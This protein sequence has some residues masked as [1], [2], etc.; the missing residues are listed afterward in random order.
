MT[1]IQFLIDIMLN[2][3]LPKPVQ[4][5][6]IARIGDV[7]KLLSQMAPPRPQP[8]MHNPYFTPNP[9]NPVTSQAPSTQR[10]LD[11]ISQEVP[12]N[13]PAAKPIPVP[14]VIDKETG[15]AIVSTGNGTKGPRKF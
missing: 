6:F 8:V 2:H 13:A 5:K 15:R 14:A 10:I 11:G 12:Y 9:Y 1:E 3:K 4:E 7:E